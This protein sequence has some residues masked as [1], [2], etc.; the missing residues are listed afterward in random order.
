MSELLDIKYKP[1]F[2]RV[3]KYM[4]AYW[5]RE[6]IDRPVVCVNA[7]MDG[8]HLPPMK[9]WVYLQNLK[10]KEDYRRK[11]EEFDE[12]AKATYY[13]GESIPFFN[14]TFGPDQYA[15]F[16]GAKIHYAS[17]T[18]TS[19]VDICLEDITK[20]NL[21]LDESKGSI[22]D[23]YLDFSRYFSEFSKGKFLLA[24]ADLHG[25]MDCL[26]ALRS[27]TNLCYDLKDEPEG[28]L[29]ALEQVL[30]PYPKI[31][32]DLFKTADV[33]NRGSIGSPMYCTGKSATIQCDFSCM[34]SPEDARRFVIPAIEMEAS[35]LEHS[36]YHFD[37]KGAL[38]HLDDVLAI[39]EIDVIQ[40]V[41]GSGEPRSM[42]WMDILKRIQAAGKGLWIYDWT[43]EEIKHFY[44][45]LRP[46]GLAFTL[47]VENPDEADEIVEWLAKNT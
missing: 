26:S 7:R 14:A 8:K 30:K 38:G 31:L 37:G 6:I 17:D 33:T 41:P 32:E 34:V 42:E 12:M 40:W 4:D 36:L 16:M 35:Y 15:A 44:K 19:W 2:A 46:E 9:R 22:Y 18:E 13:G 11:M 23:Q 39:P 1:D 21:V 27:P 43:A 5:E 25:N 47:D 3:R 20:A 28:V 29:K 10:S 24:I 45:E